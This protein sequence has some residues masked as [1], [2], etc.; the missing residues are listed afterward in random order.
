MM[1]KASFHPEDKMLEGFA[2]GSLSAGLSVAISA[3]VE[4]C[5]AC[6]EKTSALEA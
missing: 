4:R 2:S 5:A 6:R 1:N 3:H